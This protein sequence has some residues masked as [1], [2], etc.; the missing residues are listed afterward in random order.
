ME[1]L[2]NQL[3]DDHWSD[4]YHLVSKN[5]K[6]DTLNVVMIIVLKLTSEDH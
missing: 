6:F 1:K 5:F 4:V 3:G 2:L